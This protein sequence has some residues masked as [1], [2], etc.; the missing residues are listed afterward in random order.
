MAKI[1]VLHVCNQL[2]LGGT[3][4]VSQVF[5]QY[6]D[7]SCFEVFVCGRMRGRDRV[8]LLERL[9]ILVIVRPSDINH[10][11]REHKIGIYHAHRAGDTESGSLPKKHTGGRGLSRRMS[12][13]RSTSRRVS[14]LTASSSCLSSQKN[15][16]NLII[17]CVRLL[18]AKCCIIL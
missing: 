3:E 7:K 13:T 8:A 5:C 15:G 10:V 1:R 4:K 16:I 12:V 6:L 9:G 17:R 2:E 11:I 14:A 18:V